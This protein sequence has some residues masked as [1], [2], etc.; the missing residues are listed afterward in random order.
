M[1]LFAFMFIAWILF[2]IPHKSIIGSLP[3]SIWYSEYFVV[4][5]IV[6]RIQYSTT[7]N[8]LLQCFT[9]LI[10]YSYIFSNHHYITIII[11]YLSYTLSESHFET[12]W[13]SRDYLKD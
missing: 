8:V 2:E 9:H 6:V 12:H 3:D 10:K 1:H 11:T 4:F 13:S 7:D 5:C